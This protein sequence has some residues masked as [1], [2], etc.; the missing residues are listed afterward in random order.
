MENSTIKPWYKHFWPWFLIAIPC[1]SI[2]VGGIVLSF[3]TDGTNS[4]V[5]DDY[6]KE[7]KTINVKLDKLERAKQLGIKTIVDISN[8]RV[9]VEFLSGKPEAGTAL[10][11]D[12]FH[13]TIE[14]RDTEIILTRDAYGIYRGIVDFDIT[15]K[16]RLRMMPM[17]EEWKLQQRIN[18]PQS[19]PFDFTPE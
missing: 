5:V 13:A 1:S 12:F 17:D 3:A 7:G 10:K 6:Y 14:N 18:L 8:D 4:M 16:W 19:K 11:L 2:I 9:A 15:G